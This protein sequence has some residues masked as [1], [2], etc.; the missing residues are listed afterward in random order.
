MPI[1]INKH[2]HILRLQQHLLEHSPYPAQRGRPSHALAAAP[3][4][5][6]AGIWAKLGTLY[7]LEALDEREDARLWPQLDPPVWTRH[8]DEDEDEDE[9]M[10]GTE[11]R[12][13]RR[14]QGDL[15]F[16]LPMARDEE[17]AQMMWVKRF[18]S[19]AVSAST[20][21]ATGHGRK[22]RRGAGRGTSGARSESPPWNGWDNQMVRP[23]TFDVGEVREARRTEKSSTV[24]KSAQKGKSTPT[25]ATAARSRRGT[26][27]G[28]AESS[29]VVEEEEEEEEEEDDDDEDEEEDSAAGTGSSPA[30]RGSIQVKKGRGQP[31]VGTR[32]SGRKR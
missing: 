19:S 5:S 25:A 4:L 28:R 30:G 24:E 12:T 31:A 11:D 18:G 20:A 10:G 3:H 2:F 27:G 32:K 15:A 22:A 1:G 23:S 7:N 8:K 21:E 9:E 13:R 14:A 16:K 17:L 26:R 29:S 6:V